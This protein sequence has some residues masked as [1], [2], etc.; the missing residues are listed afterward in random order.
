MTSSLPERQMFGVADE[1]TPGDPLA[2]L[3]FG[4]AAFHT[5]VPSDVKRQRIVS[6]M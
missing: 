1:K 5:S 3:Y 4:N 2:V 6:S